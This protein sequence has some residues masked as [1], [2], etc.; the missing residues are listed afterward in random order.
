MGLINRIK[1]GFSLEKTYLDCIDHAGN[2]FILYS[3][4]LHFYFLQFNY[5]GFIFSDEKNLITERKS[6]YKSAL[7]SCGDKLIFVNKHFGLTGTWVRKEPPLSSVLF[8][9]PEGR[10]EWICHHPLAQCQL[11]FRKSTYSGWGYAETLLMSVKPWLLHMDLLRWGRFITNEISVIWVQWI[12]KHS[13]NKIFMNGKE[14]NDAEYFDDKIIFDG[15]RNRI[16]FSN[17]VILRQVKLSSHLSKIPYL[18]LLLS[19]TRILRSLETKYKSSAL[20]TTSEGE[21]HSGRC[22]FEK[23]IWS[24]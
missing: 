1:S 16:S 23:V 24:H 19:K 20:L 15:C 14:F 3:A 6:I 18:K 12:G 17:L 2:C 5:S 13:I 9:K 22:I 4:R 21:S 7:S 10:V 8:E 11:T